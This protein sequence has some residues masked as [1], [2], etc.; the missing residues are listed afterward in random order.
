MRGKEEKG[1]SLV[2]TLMT[3]VFSSFLMVAISDFL[4][5]QSK[6][7]RFQNLA[8]NTQQSLGSAMKMITTDVWW[9][10]F[11][12]SEASVIMADRSL[13][14]FKS[15]RN[16]DGIVETITYSRDTTSIKNPK[17]MRN[18]QIVAERVALLEFRYFDS[19]GVEL[20]NVPL[21][22][23]DRTKVKLVKVQLGSQ[24]TPQVGTKKEFILESN[25]RIRN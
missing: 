18:K 19:Q 14:T 11:N 16:G 25:A 15:D 9:I 13:F 5:F 24:V 2:E 10:G 1:Y 17:L 20:P 23:G 4:V 3:L 8:T 21:T 6:S 22:S 7:Q 12:T